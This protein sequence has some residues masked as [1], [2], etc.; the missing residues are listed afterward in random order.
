MDAKVYDPADFVRYCDQRQV[1]AARVLVFCGADKA[2]QRGRSRVAEVLSWYKNGNGALLF[3]RGG[4]QDCFLEPLKAEL[5]VDR[6]AEGNEFA[7]V[8]HGRGL[9]SQ[10]LGLLAAALEMAKAGWMAITPT[11]SEWVGGSG[12]CVLLESEAGDA[13]CVLGQRIALVEMGETRT[14]EE[15]RLLLDLIL[16]LPDVLEL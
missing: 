8:R 5:R 10:G 11:R 15:E 12:A 7:R 13:Y 2:L 1:S 14:D 16:A 4:F 3:M 6:R 9:P